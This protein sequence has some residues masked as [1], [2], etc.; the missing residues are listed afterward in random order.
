MLDAGVIRVVIPCNNEHIEMNLRSEPCEVDEVQGRQ[1][2]S[3]ADGLQYS[4]VQYSAVPYNL[5]ISAPAQALAGC[6]ERL[7]TQCGGLQRPAAAAYC[8]KTRSTPHEVCSLGHTRRSEFRSIH[9]ATQ[10]TR[11][12]CTFIPLHRLDALTS[13]TTTTARLESHDRQF[14]PT[15]HPTLMA[16]TWAIA[17]GCLVGL[18]GVALIFF[19]WWFPKTWKQGISEEMRIVDANR[20]EREL[21]QQQQREADVEAGEEH[22][23][24]TYPDEAAKPRTFQYSPPAYTTY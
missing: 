24:P 7:L 12:L 14:R 18:C 9:L 2:M 20:R 10:S 17:V 21:Y 11:H 19:W 13:D 4:T 1:S 22:P 5:G 16:P 15:L 6:G 8:S 23:P 3:P